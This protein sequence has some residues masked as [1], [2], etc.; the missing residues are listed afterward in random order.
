MEPKVS[1]CIPTY[2]QTKYLQ[3]CLDSVLA[4]SFK[5][6]EVIITDD[7]PDDKVKNFISQYKIPNLHYFK[8][9]VSLGTPGNWNAAL[10][11]ANGKYIKVM[12]H[13][14]YFLHKDSLSKF[15]K[16]AEANNCPF[17]FCNTEVWHV[18]DNSRRISSPNE[19]Q[20]KRLNNDPLFLFFRNKIGSPS[21]TLFARNGMKFDENLK[22]LVDV[23]FYINYLAKHPFI[24]INEALVCTAHETPGQVTQEVQKDKIVQIKEHVL[25]YLKVKDMVKDKSKWTS[26]FEYLFR[27]YDVK[28]LEELNNMVNIDSSLEFF[29]EVFENMNKGVGMKNFK[30]RYYNSRFNL[31]KKEQF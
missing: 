12:H 1:I 27:D 21:A 4:Q 31:S 5:D 19:V 2:K 30:R 13:D 29:K 25:V 14:D 20:L 9:P 22:W 8:N 11:R 6:F 10:S 18:S 7:T 28:S 26:F 24:H 15:V 16:T 17:V 3:K 23:D